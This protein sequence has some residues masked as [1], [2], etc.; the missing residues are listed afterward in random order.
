MAF[1]KRPLNVSRRQLLLGGGAL[2]AG[3]AL[4]LKPQAITRTTGDSHVHDA[5]FQRLSTALHGDGVATPVLLIDKQRLDANLETLLQ[6]TQDRFDY[7]IVAKSLPSIP[8]LAYVMAKAETNKLMVFHQPFLIQVTQHLPHADVLM[9]KPL[10][11]AA[12]QQFYFAQAAANTAKQTGFDDE[13]QLQWLIDSPKRLMQYKQLAETLQRRLNINIELDV[14]L[15]RGGV[16]ESSDFLTMLDMIEASPYLRF[17]G[18]MGYEPHIGKVPG[19]PINHRDEAM[20]I[21][22]KY[23]TLAETH[24]KRSIQNLTL[25]A[26]GSPTY[27]FY[28]QGAFPM[29]ELS[30]G[31]CLLK[32]SDFDLPTLHDHIAAAFIATPVLKVLPQTQIPGGFV[33]KGLSG[34]MAWWN[35]NWEQAFFVYG[36]YWK[37]KPESPKGLVL[38]P[39]YGRSSNQEMLNGSAN[40]PLKQDDWVFW[41]PTQSESVLLQFGDLL[42]L[43]H[44]EITQRW[45]VLR[46]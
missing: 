37:A 42:L 14:G 11:V 40:V 46:G 44:N 32:P 35:P 12:A 36:G 21:Y 27:Q 2:L 18:L 4:A 38:N 17:S 8:L 29:N 13:A 34:L 24:L 30:A 23:V 19:D 28:N 15:H 5:Y 9:G 7:R 43:D 41:R 22:Q 20:H 25:N 45:P 31:S 10:P 33:G 1:K 6:H 3:T 39:V 26:A 16:A